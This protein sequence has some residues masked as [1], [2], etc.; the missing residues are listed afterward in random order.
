MFPFGFS[1]LVSRCRT[2]GSTLRVKDTR[3]RPKGWH[4]FGFPYRSAKL[5][6]DKSSDTAAE[7]LTSRSHEQTGKMDFGAMTYET[8]L[9]NLFRCY[10]V[11][12]TGAHTKSTNDM[13]LS[14]DRGAS[15]C[16]QFFRGKNFN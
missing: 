5:A 4:G 10:S 16:F 14:V 2:Q 15:P 13:F 3:G 12:P 7:L 8:F 6:G 9:H 1:C 11:L